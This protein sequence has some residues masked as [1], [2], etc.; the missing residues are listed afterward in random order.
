MKD[1]YGALVRIGQVIEKVKKNRGYST[2]IWSIIGLLIVVAIFMYEFLLL[3]QVKLKGNKVEVINYKEQYKEKGYRATFLGDDITDDVKVTGEV[4]SN[5]LGKYK[6]VYTVKSGNFTKS[7]SRRV[8]VRDKSAPT[9]KLVSNDDIYVCPG[10]KYKQEKYSASDN[11]DGDI[12]KRVKV[13]EKENE[14]IYKVKDSA[15]NVRKISRKIIYKDK[16]APIIELKGSNFVYSFIGEEYNDEGYEVSDNCDS[17]LNDSVVVEGKVDNEKVGQYTINYSVKDKSGNKTKV[18][19]KVIVSNKGENGTIYLTFDDGPLNGVTNVILDVLK[20]EGVKATFFV[21]NRGSD[22][23]IKREYDEGHSVG[24]HTASHDY[25]LVYSSVDNYFNDLLTVQDRVKRITG[26]ESKIIR[27]PGGSSNTV[28]RKY[29]DGIMST[30][31]R[32]VLNRGYKYY[33]WNLESGDTS[34]VKCDAETIKN[35]VISRLSK[36][37]VNMVLMHDIKGCSRDALR[38][39]IKYAKE[40]GYSFA[41]IDMDTE[42]ITQ[43]VNN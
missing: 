19:R 7:V 43:R 23:L 22:E 16:S 5:K 21:T 18:S 41:N 24:L 39:I 13:I 38:D 27:F 29:S 35:N 25:G 10:Q 33:D 8:V 20:E 32:E 14:I 2:V 9:I 4:N 36:D 12:T 17:N 31:T 3:P 37:R 26:Y 40:N 11:Y 34:S 28:S 1:K 42:M 15:G 6:L 30:L